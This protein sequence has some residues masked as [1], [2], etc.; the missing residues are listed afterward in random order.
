MTRRGAYSA[1][2]VLNL[3][4]HFGEG[5]RKSREIAEETSVPG[6]YLKEVLAN[7]VHA[8]LVTS[9]A[10]SRGGYALS[11]PPGELNLL[12]VIEAADGRPNRVGCALCGD[13]CG[14]EGPCPLREAWERGL[15]AQI[16]EL[17]T[18]TFADLGAV[19]RERGVLPPA[20]DPE[21]SEG[22]ESPR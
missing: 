3:G 4:E 13:D 22:G 15:D 10:G 20:A 17:E 19:L 18:T 5:L 1:L 7:L 21:S 8:G 12:E 9:V 11:R 6:Y 14:W 2:A 16:A